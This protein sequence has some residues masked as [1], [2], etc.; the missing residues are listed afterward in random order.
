[1]MNRR[2]LIQSI[3]LGTAGV[4]ISDK[5]FANMEPDNAEPL[6]L[7]GNINHSV[8]SWTYNFLPLD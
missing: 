1:M 5:S 8:A 3:A 4:A 6:A 2:Q 7:K